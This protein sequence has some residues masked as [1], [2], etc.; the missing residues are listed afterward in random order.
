MLRAMLTIVSAT[1]V[2]VHYVVLLLIVRACY[3]TYIMSRSDT[4]Q[5]TAKAV[6]TQIVHIVFQRLLSGEAGYVQPVSLPDLSGFGAR[7]DQ[8]RDAATAQGVVMSVWQSLTN[9]EPDPS[10]VLNSD[11]FHPPDGRCD[12]LAMDPSRI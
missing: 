8:R 2:Q 7:G 11:A 1:A 4:T 10:A 5:Q 6:L 3:N 12:A 9:P